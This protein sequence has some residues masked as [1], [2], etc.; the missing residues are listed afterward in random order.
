MRAKLYEIMGEVES[1]AR[2]M[3]EGYADIEPELPA[4]EWPLA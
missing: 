3:P 1:G 4:L 2:P